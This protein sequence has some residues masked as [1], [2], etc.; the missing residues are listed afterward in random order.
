MDTNQPTTPTSTYAPAPTASGIFG[1]KIPSS[2]AF[3]VGILLFLMPFAELKCTSKADKEN[4]GFSFSS[5]AFKITNSGLGLA[6]GSQWKVKMG[7]FGSLMGDEKNSMSEKQDK[8]SPNVFAIAALA[9]GVLGLGLSIAKLKS[10]NAI[11]TVSGVLSAGALV[12]LMFDL[13]SKMKDMKMPSKGSGGNE[14]NFLRDMGDVTFKLGFTPW[15]YV[16]IVAFLAAA[17]F[18]YKRMQSSKT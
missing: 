6:M 7:G 3:A 1:T 2:V 8:Q 14:D 13:K 10:G 9:L 12:G 11:A 18:C 17:F 16:A 5:S 4:S 15:F